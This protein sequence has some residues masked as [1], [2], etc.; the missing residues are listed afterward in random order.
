MTP[1]EP[2]RLVPI[3]DKEMVVLIGSH[4]RAS[5]D[6]Q[7]AAA[8]LGQEELPELAEMAET[9]AAELHDLRRA[10]F[11]ESNEAKL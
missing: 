4:L 1:N 5:H 9:R 6:H 11:P 3:T 8:S 10:L 2:R 7:Q